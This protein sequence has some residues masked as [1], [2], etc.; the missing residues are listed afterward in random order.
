MFGLTP[1]PFG[2]YI[3]FSTVQ[4]SVKLFDSTFAFLRPLFRA[5]EH[6]QY[7]TAL[8]LNPTSGR[9]AI[10]QQN[11]IVRLHKL[12]RTRETVEVGIHSWL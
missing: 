9:V 4:N 11:G 3:A 10:G 6:V 2:A 7:P 5:S 1:D 12:L 8:A